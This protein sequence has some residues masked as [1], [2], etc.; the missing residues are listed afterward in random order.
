MTQFQTIDVDKVKL[1]YA[2]A[3]GP[4]PALVFLHGIT[5]SHT[6]FLPFMPMLAKQ[7]HIYALDLR[8]HGLSD[9][10]PGTY[11]VADYG[12]DVVAFLRTVVGR[13]AIIA[14]FS[15][16]GL[17]GAWIAGQTPD[18]IQKLFLEEPAL[19]IIQMPRFKESIFYGYF[20]TLRE[21][22][23]QHHAA[24]GT[25]DDMIAY[26]GAFPV[27]EEH[28]MIE[29]AGP[30]IVRERAIQGHQMDPTTFD[31]FIEG[32][33]LDGQD[34]DDLLEKIRCP[35]H[36][37]AGQMAL[38]GALSPEDVQRAIS[39]LSDCTYTV[40]EDVGHGIHQDRPEEY[41]QALQQFLSAA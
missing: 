40:V 10:T 34:A 15:L 26:V 18:L 16:G 17:V 12:R 32:V 7:A 13:P 19:Y 5:G 8:G 24:G 28:T 4:G 36:L 33:L 35:V 11:Q 29:I 9:Q 21:H 38:G 14:G 39:K 6:D 31:P 41:C 25:L 37:M 23:P 20:T 1:H 22:L 3:P 2:E 30:E 27:T